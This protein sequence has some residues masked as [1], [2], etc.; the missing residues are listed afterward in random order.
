ALPSPAALGCAAPGLC[1]VGACEVG[2]GACLESGG[3]CGECLRVACNTAALMAG[4]QP[5][6]PG[7]GACLDADAISAADC[8]PGSDPRKVVREVEAAAVCP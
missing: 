1:S 8:P 7:G 6:C 2:G 5:A 3:A 4:A